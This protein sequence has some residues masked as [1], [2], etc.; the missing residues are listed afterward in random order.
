MLTRCDFAL[1]LRRY[2]LFIKPYGSIQNV[3][4]IKDVYVVS[5]TKRISKALMRSFAHALDVCKNKSYL[6]LL[7]LL[8][9][10]ISYRPK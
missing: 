3:N 8:I 2:A 5:H 9:N 6:L 4:Q 10:F 7:L 1:Y